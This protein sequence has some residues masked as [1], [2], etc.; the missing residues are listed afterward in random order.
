MT[1]P[2]TLS[3]PLIASFRCAAFVGVMLLFSQPRARRR[4]Y[5]ARRMICSPSSRASTRTSTPILNS[6]CR[7]SGRPA[8]PLSGCA[9]TDTR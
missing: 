8:L 5:R 4:P 1:S 2:R 7:N 9:S 3:M 6:R